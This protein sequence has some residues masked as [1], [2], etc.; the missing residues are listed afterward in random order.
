MLFES[1]PSNGLRVVEAAHPRH[2]MTM[3]RQVA[4][5]DREIT[6]FTEEICSHIKTPTATASEQPHQNAHFALWHR[7]SPFLPFSL[8]S[9]QS[10]YFQ[11]YLIRIILG[12]AVEGCFQSAPNQPVPSLQITRYFTVLR[13]ISNHFDFYTVFHRVED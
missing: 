3:R 2:R 1:W 4:A 9:E 6:T 5:Y 11:V 7:K 8:G 13:G 10:L 12:V